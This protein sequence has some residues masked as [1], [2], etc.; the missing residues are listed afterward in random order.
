MP[1]LLLNYGHQ[2]SDG[3][4]IHN[5]SHKDFVN[6][7]GDFQ[8][9][10]KQIITTYFGYSNS[11]DE[12]SGE[13]T[14]TQYGA[15]DF[16]GNIEY[17]KRNGHSNVYTMRAGLGQTYIFNSHI[18]NTTTV[19]G[20]GFNSNASSAG[21]WTDKHATNLGLRSTV[22]IKF[23]C[24]EGVNLS[25]I[26]G[27][28]TQRQNATTIG[29][30]MI[31]PQGA[32]HIWNIGDPYFIIG[33]TGTNGIT[34]D[35]YTTTTTNSLFT[36]W[37]L[38]MPHDLSITGGIGVSNMKIK[39]DDRFYVANKPTHYDTTYKNMFS[40]H[41]AINKVFSKQFSLYAAYSK[42]Y[43]APVSSYFFIP[44]ASAFV[45]ETGI[46]NRKLRPE[47]GNQFEIG[48]KGALHNGNLTYQVAL[49]DAVFSHKMTVVAVPFNAS[50]TLY[51]YVTNAG[52][53]DDKGIEILI[54]YTAYKSI[55]GF[56]RTISPFA[57][58]AYSDFNYGDNY[59]FQTFS[60]TNITTVDYSNKSVA[61]V[62]K[63]LANAGVDLLMAAGIYANLN[64][65]YKE[66]FPITSDG[67]LK[68][69]SYNLVNL[70][71]GIL[72][73]LSKHFDI[74]A[75]WGINNIGGTKYPIMV[76]VNQIPDA[77]IAGPPKA[78][79]FGEINLKY[80]FK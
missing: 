68:T 49:F 8:P 60:G 70:K 25:G 76:F 24:K 43:K 6:I 69:T 71:L 36:E 80:N 33:S 61:G 57:N 26:T 10:A 2:K 63:L 30:S 34:S 45:G 15:D 14:I 39:L 52:K 56:F 16:S 13:L 48:T 27:V 4:T 11:Y 77:Y 54:K 58:L 22:E 19:F 42:G 37:T 18:T 74:D 20:T 7:A 50:T 55:N 23:S 46:V 73:Q 1:A 12:R 79:Y 40:P 65:L 17:I 32:S 35:I 66:G 75:F 9:N 62:A 44:F 72:H 59:K 5:A 3:F 64:Y 53:Q 38:A 51:S 78:N 67:I 21:G 29:Y 47:S 41:L 31:D 28:E